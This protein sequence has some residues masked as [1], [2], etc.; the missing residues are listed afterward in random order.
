[1]I[2]LPYTS[3]TEEHVPVY[4]TKSSAGFDVIANEDITLSPMEYK[5]VKTGWKFALP[6]GYAFL[7]C[8]RSGQ[9]V[10]KGLISHIAP[11][12]LDSDYRGECFACMR[13]VST[14]TITIKKGERIAQFVIVPIVQADFELVESLDATERGEGGF[15]STGTK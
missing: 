2:K 3:E 14:E 9:A 13:N 8:S 11:G 4:G 7:S 12:V 1:M 6:E 5:P 10:K 15:G